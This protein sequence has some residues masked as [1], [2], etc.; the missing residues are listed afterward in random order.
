MSTA[1]NPLPFGAT[2]SVRDA[3]KMAR[4]KAKQTD[5][6]EEKARLELIAKTCE[7]VPEHPPE[8]FIEALQSFFFIHLARNLEFS[9]LGFGVRFDKVFGPYYE[10]DLKAG[11]LNREEAMTIESRSTDFSAGFLLFHDN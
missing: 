3:K 1:S 2:I 8:T 5:N 10:A 7:R 6:R 9:T 11:R 4:K